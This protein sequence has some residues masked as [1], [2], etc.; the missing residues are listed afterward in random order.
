MNFDHF[1]EI[2]FRLYLDKFVF[3]CQWSQHW[4][5]VLE[6]NYTS[7]KRRFKKIKKH[8]IGGGFE[9]RSKD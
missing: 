4:S 7:R 6:A 1:Q 5:F 8:V 3:R 2:V 9:Q